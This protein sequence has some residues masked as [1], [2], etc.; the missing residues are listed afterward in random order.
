MRHQTIYFQEYSLASHPRKSWVS[1]KGIL[2]EC[3]MVCHRTDECIRVH[4]ESKSVQ[5]RLGVGTPP[6][7][8]GKSPDTLDTENNN[9]NAS[10]MFL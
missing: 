6:P 7:H 9:I 3:V 4:I 8:N 5:E 2:K 10:I 1:E